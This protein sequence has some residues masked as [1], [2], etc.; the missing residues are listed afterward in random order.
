M[1][2]TLTWPVP[3]IPFLP[4]HPSSFLRTEDDLFR[5]PPEMKQPKAL[6]SVGRAFQPYVKF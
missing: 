5:L 1:N 2:K 4:G 3:R 6:R